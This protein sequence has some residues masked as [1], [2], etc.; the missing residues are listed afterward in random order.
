[1]KILV[2][3]PGSTSTKIA[4]FENTEVVFELKLDHAKDPEFQQE[5]SRPRSVFDQLEFRKKALEQAIKENNIT[6]LC[7]R[8]SWWHRSWN[9]FRYLFR[10]RKNDCRF[11]K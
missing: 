4:V 9:S 2:I 6:Q 1:M 10:Q 8:R 3:N 7:C 5:F 11:I